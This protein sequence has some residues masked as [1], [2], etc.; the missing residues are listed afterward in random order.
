VIERGRC[1]CLTNQPGPRDGIAE[2]RYR[3]HLDRHVAI[4]LLI[5]RAIHLAHPTGAQPADDAI[6]RQPLAIHREIRAEFY[7]FHLA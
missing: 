6:V 7:P 3:E 5:A 4:Q 1:T 2:V